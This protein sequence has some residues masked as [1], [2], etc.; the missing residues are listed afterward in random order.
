MFGTKCSDKVKNI[1]KDERQLH[2]LKQFYIKQKTGIWYIR[3]KYTP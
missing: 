3:N 1:M 2:V